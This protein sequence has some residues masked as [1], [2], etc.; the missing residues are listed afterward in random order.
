[1]KTKLLTL[2][3]L[4]TLSFSALANDYFNT[5]DAD[6]NGY[7]DV[8][9]HLQGSKAW[10]DKADIKEEKRAQMNQNGFNKKDANKDGKVTL[11]EFM[12]A[13]KKNKKNK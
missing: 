10:M 9:E 7:I 4:I 12:A 3:A 13:K 2:T 8:A 6:S 11:E 5:L 1:M